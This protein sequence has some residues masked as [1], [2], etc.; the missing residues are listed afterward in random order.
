MF[1]GELCTYVFVFCFVYLQLWRG[2][3]GLKQQLDAEQFADSIDNCTDQLHQL[4]QRWHS[5][6]QA[7]AQTFTKAS[8]LVTRL[9]L[10][11]GVD[12][13]QAQ[14]QLKDHV[15]RLKDQHQHVEM[16]WQWRQSCLEAWLSMY[17]YALDVAMVREYC[18]FICRV[19]QCACV[20]VCLCVGV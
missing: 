5:D 15:M 1:C 3:A 13:R 7:A 16:T 18:D 8:E 4:K 19:C 10:D 6:N 17:Q 20:S 9:Q 12:Y 2:W 11:V 14:Q